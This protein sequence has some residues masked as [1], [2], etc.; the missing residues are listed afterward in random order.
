MPPYQFPGHELK[1][2]HIRDIR[3]DVLDEDGRFQILPASF[4]RRTSA[5]ER[6]LFGHRTGIYSFPT[7][8]LVDRLKQII[9]GR[10]AIEIGA[11][12]G[13][14][15]EALGIPATDSFQ[16]TDPKY[17]EVYEAIDHT[18]VPYS[19][20]VEKLTAYDAVRKYEPQVV[21]GCWVT[22]KWNKNEPWRG[23]NE[24]GID[25]LD[26][27]AHCEEYVFVGNMSPATGHSKKPIWRT[28][29][30]SEK[31]DYIY[32]RSKDHKR[33]FLGRWYGA[34]YPGS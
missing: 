17:R 16:Q 12:N 29:H 5:N 25:E 28:L 19:P 24:V 8:E 9:G 6:V 33:D 13:V 4:W 26:I 2:A 31:H 3:P 20:K 7:V 11:G 10:T 18:A 22:H 27:L 21:L 34:R 1:P 15:A 14:L 32:S 30:K 23:G